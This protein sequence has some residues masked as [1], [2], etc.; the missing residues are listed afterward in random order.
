MILRDFNC[1]RCQFTFEALVGIPETAHPCPKCG[2]HV[3]KIITFKGTI[4]IA[5]T[6]II[7]DP[8]LLKEVSPGK[9]LN[10]PWTE[11]R[12]HTKTKD[13][14][15]TLKDGRKVRRV[16]MDVGGL[17]PRRDLNSN[18]KKDIKRS[19]KKN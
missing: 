16:S 9:D 18:L 19:T 2:R 17:E 8:G 11:E 15:K 1:N 14:E 6:P 12:E 3:Q 13:I 5:P 4:K 7:N 10:R